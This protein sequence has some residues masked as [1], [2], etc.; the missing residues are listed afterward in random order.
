MDTWITFWGWLLLI[1]LFVYASLAVVITLGGFF[2]V[3]EMLT[4]IDKQH[5]PNA[6]PDTKDKHD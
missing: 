4:T 5:H 6:D 2:D 3:K 1:V